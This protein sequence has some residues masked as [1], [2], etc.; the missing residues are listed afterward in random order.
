[1][2]RL[3]SAVA[4]VFVVAVALAACSDD[5]SDKVGDSR[6]GTSSTTA[7]TT[8][9]PP[10]AAD[11]IV[12]NGEGNNL[13]AYSG[14]DPF[15]KQVVITNA[16]EDPEHGLDINGQIC[17]DP[18]DPQRFIAGEDT[19]QDTTGHPGWGLF[20][21]SGDEI[22]KLEAK[23]VAKLVPTYQASDDNPENYG[24]GFL[25]DGRVLTTDIG[26][27]A[28]GPGDGQLIVWFPPFSFDDNSYCKVDVE[29]TTGQGIALDDTSVYVAEARKPGV[30]RYPIAS[31]PT[32]A[33]AAGGCG[34]LDA[35]GAPLADANGKQPFIL[36]TPENHLATPN[37][38]V[39]DRKGHFFVSSVFNG[40]IAEF[41]SDGGFVRVV[42]EPPAGET[43]GAEPFST[44]TPLGIGLDGDGNLYYADIGIVVGEGV[45]PGERTGTVRK[46]AFVDGEPQAPMVMDSGLAFPDGIGIYAAPTN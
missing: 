41:N 38:I 45:G 13:S 34:R 44:G 6:P 7:P 35:T 14:D 12:L 21:L 30:F 37:A 24:C 8:V 25:P 18:A 43:L 32:G 16:A 11:T 3:V 40:V 5:G 29:L 15:R 26:N 28:S 23:Q 39:R 31:L 36:P 33:D 10:K 27:Q 42:L 17:F 22:G 19:N 1:M 46:I 20:D 4:L 2:R 9:A